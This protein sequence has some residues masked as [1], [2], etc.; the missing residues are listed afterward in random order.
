MNLYADTSALVKKYVREAGSEQVIAFFA[1][2]PLIGT[3]VLTQA[4]V[5]SAMSKALRSGWVDEPAILAAWQDFLSHWPAYVRLPI[6]AGIVEHAAAIAQQYGLRA[7]DA[8][9]LASALA[10]EDVT[11]DEVV[12]ACYDENLAKAA[13]KEGLQI[14]P[15]N[16]DTTPPQR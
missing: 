2:H 15:G 4:E 5:A 14:W 12:F 3:A 9:H 13:G 6:S 11:G 10:W 1:Q 8:I 7:Y 16:Y